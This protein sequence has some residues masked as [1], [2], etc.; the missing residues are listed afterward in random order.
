MI[1]K[2]ATDHWI[3]RLSRGHV[4]S[5]HDARI[6]VSRCLSTSDG[7]NYSSWETQAHEGVWCR[8][9][10]RLVVSMVARTFEDDDLPTWA[11]RPLQRA[12][13]RARNRRERLC[14]G[15]VLMRFLITFALK[16]G[17]GS[18][19]DQ[20]R[21]LSLFAKWQPPVE[22]QEWESSCARQGGTRPEPTI[23]TPPTNPVEDPG[24]SA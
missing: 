18:E 22:L 19:A 2:D 9:P 13:S 24:R 17:S 14:A 15:G 8:R 6:G 10:V 7:V 4:G 23:V 11:T 16:S 5:R 12:G 21:I 3:S 1:H 20:A